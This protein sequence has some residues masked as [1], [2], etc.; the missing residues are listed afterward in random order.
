MKVIQDQNARAV[1]LGELGQ[2]RTH[3]GAFRRIGDAG[4]RGQQLGAGNHAAG[5]QGFHQVA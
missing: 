4:G 1:A 2:H 5:S 3:H